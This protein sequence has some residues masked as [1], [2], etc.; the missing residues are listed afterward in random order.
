MHMNQRRMFIMVRVLL[1]WAF[2]PVVRSYDSQAF[3]A[4]EEQLN[5]VW[6]IPDC[7]DVNAEAVE[8]GTFPADSVLWSE[9]KP[10]LAAEAYPKNLPVVTDLLFTKILGEAQQQ[11]LEAMQNVLAHASNTCLFGVS[12]ILFFYTKYLTEFEDDLDSAFIYYS[13]F[14]AFYAGSHPSLNE[15]GEWGFSGQDVTLLRQQ[16]LERKYERGLQAVRAEDEK[17]G[18]PTGEN[19]RSSKTETST[20]EGVISDNLVS[21]SAELLTAANE[22]L[23]AYTTSFTTAVE[24]L[25]FHTNGKLVVRSSDNMKDYIISPENPLVSSRL[26][27]TP[28]LTGPIDRTN[29][30]CDR[31]KEL[32]DL[33]PQT[34]YFKQDKTKKNSQLKIYVYSVTEIPTLFH[35][36]AQAASFCGRGQWASEV[37]FHDWLMQHAR[38]RTKNPKEADYFFVP[39]YAICIFESGFLQLPEIDLAYRQLVTEL[40]YFKHNQ[41][42]HFFTFGS[43]MGINVFFSWRQVFPESIFLTPETSLYNDFPHITKAPFS[44]WKDIAI[45]GYM[46]RQEIASLTAAAKPVGEKKYTVVF[47]GRTDPSRGVHPALGGTDVRNEIVRVMENLE[48]KEDVYVGYTSLHE[49]HFLMGD[50]K[51]C[52]VPRGKSAWSLRLYEA[53]FADCIP[54]LLSDFW[55]LPFEDFIDYSKMLIKWPANI[56]TPELVDYLRSIPTTVLDRMVEEIHRVRCWFVYPSVLAEIHYS[57]PV[58]NNL[59]FLCRNP[60]QFAGDAIIEVLRRKNLGARDG[61]PERGR[62]FALE[63]GSGETEINEPA[64]QGKDTA[65]VKTRPSKPAVSAEAATVDSSSTT[66]AA[67]TPVVPREKVS[68]QELNLESGQVDPAKR[69]VKKA[70]DERIVRQALVEDE[71]EVPEQ[72]LAEEEAIAGGKKTATT[73]SFSIKTNQVLQDEPASKTGKVVKPPSTPAQVT[74]TAVEQKKPAVTTAPPAVKPPPIVVTDASTVEA[75]CASAKCGRQESTPSPDLVVDGAKDRPTKKKARKADPEVGAGMDTKKS[76]SSPGDA[77]TEIGRTTEE[78]SILDSVVSFFR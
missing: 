7:S 32:L 75:N 52:F 57:N 27:E 16:L 38:L 34:K 28:P 51:F 77:A 6:N 13:L 74:A 47:F 33:L 50:S 45:P 61:Y 64:E 15:K 56:V 67:G 18:D 20:A 40:P 41:R 12:T 43:G 63:D 46:H 65:P 58:E 36:L 72:T 69:L 25:R 44:S 37:H 29:P 59:P 68:A 54:V 23:H 2:A 60:E 31:S 62:D 10:R 11:G 14:D 3:K 53:L 19:E 66:P 17:N 30:P 73:L 9:E 78:G 24:G 8:Q 4:S 5:R 26:C 39:G 48:Q 22:Q 21:Q 35:H 70:I 49:M 55:E 76:S 71:T 1:A 42:K